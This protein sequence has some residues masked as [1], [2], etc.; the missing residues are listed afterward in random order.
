MQRKH[1]CEKTMN[2]EKSI[3]CTMCK[4]HEM[5]QGTTHLEQDGRGEGVL[6]AVTSRF[7]SVGKTSGNRIG[8]CDI[9]HA[10]S[11]CSE[12]A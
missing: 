2:P 1:A 4:T 7:R 12:L 10:F 5:T 8:K 9:K 3:L 11:D 6:Q